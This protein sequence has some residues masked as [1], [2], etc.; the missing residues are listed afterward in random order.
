MGA[1]VRHGA[2][3]DYPRSLPADPKGVVRRNPEEPRAEGRRI[4]QAVAA[5]VCRDQCLGDDVLGFARVVEDEVGDRVELATVGRQE[6]RQRQLARCRRPARPIAT[7][8]V[9]SLPSSRP[10]KGSFGRIDA[11]APHS[12]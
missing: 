7:H 1:H 4:A 2:E 11:R 5:L 6:F 3:L 12:G 9:V 8:G 10:T